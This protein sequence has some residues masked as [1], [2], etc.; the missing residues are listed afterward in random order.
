MPNPPMNIE[1]EIREI[2]GMV[3]RLYKSSKKRT[4]VPASWVKELTG[5]SNKKMM[6]AREK[7]IVEYRT[8]E[9]GG[10]DYLLESIP[11]QLLINK[12][13]QP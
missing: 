9:N 11:E 3:A 6:T 13:N 5:W 2:K 10:Y 12:Q 4:W 8:N 7:R 1:S